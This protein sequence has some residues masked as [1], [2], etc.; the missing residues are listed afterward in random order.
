MQRQEIWSLA[1]AAGEGTRVLTSLVRDVHSGIAGRVFGLIGPVAKPVEVIHNTVAAFTYY[2]VD[3]SVRGSLKGAGAL[4]AEACASD[5]EDTIIDSRPKVTGAIAALNGIYGDEL[6]DRGN[7]LAFTMQVRQHDKPVDL[8]AAAIAAAFPQATGRIA[9]F[10]H[11]WCMS[12]RAWR[13]RPRTGERV[14]P[15]G[16]RLE[17]DLGFTA[18][19]LRYN[20]GLHISHNGRAVADL[21][22]QLHTVWPV[23]VEEIALIGHSMGGLVLRSAC[24]YGAQQQHSWPDAVR[25]V[26]CLSSPNLGAD[27]EKGV[28][29]AAWALARLPETRAIASFLNLR[30]SGVKDMRYGA[31]L[32]EDWSGC[33]PDEYLRDRCHEVP[34]LPTAVYHFVATSVGRRAVALMVGDRLVRPNSASGVGK[35]RRIPFEPQH[36]LTLTGLNHFDLLNH[37]SIYT[38]L[39]EWLSQPAQQETAS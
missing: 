12:D 15:Y 25:H 34:F 22:N 4:A 27:L 11:G 30:S 35:S 24:H 14:R 39:V 13:R 19:Y 33:D 31:C 2:A 23:P 3:R 8:T 37:P 17:A 32:D 29:A 21:L 16:A 18:V 38:K 28:N 9:V 6:A 5:E 1:D 7:E 26:I 10:V 36:G 20:T